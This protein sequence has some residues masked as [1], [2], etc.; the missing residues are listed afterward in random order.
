[1]IGS[2]ARLCALVLTALAMLPAPGEAQAPRAYGTRIGA[3]PRTAT[4]I[5]DTVYIEAVVQLDIEAGPGAIISALA[6]DSTLL[7]PVRPYFEMAGIR[8]ASFARGDSVLAILEPGEVPV[9]F[10]PGQRRITRGGAPVRH[11]STDQVFWEDGELYVATHVLDRLL[12]TRTSMNWPTLSAVVGAS[13]GLPVVQRARRERSRAVLGARRVAPGVLEMP[14]DEHAVDGVVGTWAVN[15]SSSGP[16]N[17][18]GLDLGLGGGLL[19]GSAELRHVTYRNRGVATSELRLSWSRVLHSPYVRQ[20]RLGDV[21]S[22]GPVATNAPFVRSVEFDAENLQGRAPAGWEVE[23]YDRGRLLAY[24]EVDQ[25]GVFRVPLELRY[26]QNPFEL[27]LYGPAG[28]TIRQRRTIR[29][30]FSRL[31]AGRLEYSVAAGACRYDPCDGL[32][33]TDVRY[34]LS[35]LVTV[36]GGWEGFFHRDSSLWQPYALVSAAPL[37]SLAITGEGVL[38]G[39]LRLSAE[40][41]PHLDLRLSG[42]ITKNAASGAAYGARFN[43]S[44]NGDLSLYWRPGW[45]AGQLFFQGSGMI[46]A[47][48]SYTR[49][50]V[51]LAATTRHRAIRYSLGTLADVQHTA[52]GAGPRRFTVDAGAD[53]IISSRSW[54]WL[55]TATAG[56]QIAVDPAHGFTAL[57]ATVGRRLSRAWRMDAGL[58]WYREAGAS[59]ELSFASMGAGPRM[60]SRQRASTVTGTEGMVYANGSVAFD[61]RSGLVRLGDASSLGRAGI[62]GKMF[63]DDNANGRQDLGEPGIAGIPVRVGGWLAETDSS[64]SFSAW[65]LL[66]FEPVRIDVD[67]LSFDNPQFML[68]APVIVVRPAPNSFGTVNV[69]VLVGAEISGYVVLDDV[70]LGG[71]PVV[72]RELNTGAE[73]TTVTFADGVFYRSSIPPGEYEVT[74]PEAVLERLGALAPPLSILVPPGAGEKRYS[75]LHLRLERRQ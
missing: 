39:H 47:G 40:F 33:S 43:E 60:G 28:E 45:M 38:N 3:R 72:L 30:P 57:R 58:G 55:N 66:P 71:I 63:R 64:G 41:E 69:P 54:R 23:L 15:A 70:A 13:A 19:G 2:R 48:P 31:P 17:Q 12:H 6:L 46:S 35:R 7:L 68:P 18:L 50:L 62:T 16:T 1:V 27:V 53:A 9:V 67:S 14:L 59:L 61:P 75:D 74:L 56:G 49:R 8:I 73:F 29:V 52:G 44:T 37:P 22:A 26:G 42:G 25:L 4:I 34:G 10:K 51:R 11:D 21:Q 36:Q 5:R 20:I 32:M 24:S 65:G